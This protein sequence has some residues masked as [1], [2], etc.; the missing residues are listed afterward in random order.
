[1]ETPELQNE[2]VLSHRESK[3][4]AKLGTALH[5]LGH[6]LGAPVEDVACQQPPSQGQLPLLPA[7]CVQGLDH[8]LEALECDAVFLLLHL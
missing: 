5:L 7:Q 8:T 4:S 1:M 3:Q 6:G 2:R